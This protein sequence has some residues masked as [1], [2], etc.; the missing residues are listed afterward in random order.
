MGPDCVTDKP[1]GPPLII[2]EELCMWKE[3]PGPLIETEPGVEIETPPPPAAAIMAA[4]CCHC[5]ICIA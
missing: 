2:V 1:P 5:I 3:P 4:C